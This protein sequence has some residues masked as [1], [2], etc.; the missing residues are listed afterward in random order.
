MIF[1][2]VIETGEKTFIRDVTKIEKGW[3]TE[4][5]PAYYQIR[6]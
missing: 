2:E 5:A 6:K 4:Y 3:L 1:H